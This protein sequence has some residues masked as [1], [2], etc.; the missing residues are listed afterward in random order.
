MFFQDFDCKFQNNYF[1]KRLLADTSEICFIQFIFN[2]P[3]I[4]KKCSLFCWE[5]IS[6]NAE[7][8]KMRFNT[9]EIQ[10]F[11]FEAG[12]LPLNSHS[13]IIPEYG[14]VNNTC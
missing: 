13:Q 7:S 11:I 5:S 8:S 4:K 9:K 2:F 10:V 3:F 6:C 12:Q 14:T 1:P